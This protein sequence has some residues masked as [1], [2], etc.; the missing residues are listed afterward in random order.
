MRD[1]EHT[2]EPSTADPNVPQPGG[3]RQGIGDA[4][5]ASGGSRGPSDPDA[6][7]VIREDRV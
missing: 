3:P 6:G 7:P 5:E 4:D 2:E 1:E